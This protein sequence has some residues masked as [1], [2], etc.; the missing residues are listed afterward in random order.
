MQFK[1]LLSLAFVLPATVSATVCSGYSIA[2]FT[3]V[4]SSG[5]SYA[6]DTDCTI[7]DTIYSSDSVSSVDIEGTTYTCVPASDPGTCGSSDT[8]IS[9]Q[10]PSLCCS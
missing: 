8:Q 5:W 7:K 6:S 1:A 4:N 9:G 10:T 3:D 2:Y